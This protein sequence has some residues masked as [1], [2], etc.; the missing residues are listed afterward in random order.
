MS[1]RTKEQIAFI[2][3]NYFDEKDIKNYQYL[4]KRQ[5]RKLEAFK[6]IGNQPMV[7]WI[8]ND[9]DLIEKIIIRIKNG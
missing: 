7:K 1:K 4:V 6:S 9:I 2:I 3:K 5:K 8:E